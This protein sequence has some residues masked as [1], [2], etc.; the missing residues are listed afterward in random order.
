MTGVLDS[1]VTSLVTLQLGGGLHDALTPGGRRRIDVH[2]VRSV[3]GR[4]TPGPTLCGVD[5]FAP[6]VGWSLGGGVDGPSIT[7]QPCAG[8]L[9][10]AHTDF[11]GLA[12]HGLGS[13]VFAILKVPALSIRP[14]WAQCIMGRWK[15]CEN[16]TWSTKYRGMLLVHASQTYEREGLEFA[17]ALG[18]PPGHLTNP[19]WMSGYLGVAELTDVHASGDC[20]GGCGPWGAAGQFHWVMKLPRIFSQ[21]VP[22]GGK[23]G[24]Y[25]KG[26]P[27]EVLVAA[28]ALGSP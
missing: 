14:P 6:G 23:L 15:P 19:R 10:T 3:A 16:R 12:V 24:L 27:A 8:C 1:T 20:N 11:H 26:I 2:L 5:R 4:G 22:G 13:D 18:V 9:T 25:R 21:P 28:A 7:M 17:K